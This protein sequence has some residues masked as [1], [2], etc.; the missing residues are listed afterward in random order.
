MISSSPSLAHLPPMPGPRGHWLLGHLTELKHDALETFTG[1]Q[2][3]H[4]DIVRLK[5]LGLGELGARFDLHVLAH[6]DDISYVLHENAANYLNAGLLRRRYHTLF[7][8]C[9]LAA[10]GHDWQKRRKLE[11]PAFGR[12]RLNEMAVG[13]TDEAEVTIKRWETRLDNGNASFNAVPDMMEL[14]MRVAGRMLLST[15]FGVISSSLESERVIMARHM[16]MVCLQENLPV[17][18]QLPEKSPLRFCQSAHR[19]VDDRNHRTPPRPTRSRRRRKR[20]A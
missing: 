16:D 5:M 2:R 17:V 10:E 14:S 1:V 3:T 13:V 19:A 20:L 8:P 7:G 9:I 4:G 15:D 11:A 18:N 6:P 12:S